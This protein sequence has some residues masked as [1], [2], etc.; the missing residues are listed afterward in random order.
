MCFRADSLPLDQN[1]QIT[2][3]DTTRTF[4][5]S[6]LLCN[7]N[8]N[9]NLGIHVCITVFMYSSSPL[10]RPPYLSRNCGHIRGVAFVRGRSKCRVACLESSH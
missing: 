1:A 6:S 2:L 7:T 8:G 4:N 5:S 3:N 10:I 9:T